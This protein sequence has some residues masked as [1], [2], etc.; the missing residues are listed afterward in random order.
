M[1]E[2]LPSKHTTLGSILRFEGESYFCVQVPT[3]VRRCWIPW[4][5]VEITDGGML[6]DVGARNQTGSLQERKHS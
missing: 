1:V 3:E 6:P 4:L 5:E 2:H